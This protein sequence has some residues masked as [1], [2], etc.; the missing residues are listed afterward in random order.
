MKNL[1]YIKIILFT[2]LFIGCGKQKTEKIKADLAFRSV[3]FSSFYGAT[4]E[5]YESLVHEVDSTLQNSSEENENL[6]LCRYFKKLQ[7]L[8]LLRS[9]YI[10]LNIEKDSVITVYLSENEYKKVKEIRHVDLF[11]EG[12]KVVLE[13]ELIEKAKGIYYTENI[14]EVKKIDGKSR[15][16]ISN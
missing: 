13:L 8:S 12:K 9:P 6:K 14:L 11:K 15:S 16:N 3:T 10:F 7:K 5:R 2:F 4:D 1:H